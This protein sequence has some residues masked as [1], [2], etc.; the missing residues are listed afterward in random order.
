MTP[1]LTLTYDSPAHSSDAA[2]IVRVRF[3][4]LIAGVTPPDA[5]QPVSADLEARIQSAAQERDY[6]RAATVAIEGYGGELLGYLHALALT[7]ADA[8]ELFS[9]MCERIWRSL[10]KFRWDCTFR[11]WSYRIARNLIT[12]RHRARAA[13]RRVVALDEV[14][15]ISKLADRV[16]TSTAHHLK[17]E[18]KTQLQQLRDALDPDDRTLLVLRLDR[19]LPWREIAAVMSEGEQDVDK[20]AGRLRK[21]FERLKSHLREQLAP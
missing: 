15:E 5:E 21:R 8:D 10:P 6:E 3:D 4:V 1:L 19:R 18:V 13:E 2:R 12:D 16:R 17:S 20:R 14:S 9:E 11:T 7:P